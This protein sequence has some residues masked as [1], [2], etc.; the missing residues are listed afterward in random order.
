MLRNIKKLPIFIV[1]LV[2]ACYHSLANAND[3]P[4]GKLQ[5]ELVN[6]AFFQ[7]DRDYTGGLFIR[8][9]PL[10][11]AYTLRLGQEIYTPDHLGRSAPIND[12]HPYAGWSYLGASYKYQFSNRWIVDFTLDAGTI[13]PRSG[14]RLTQTFLHWI[15]SSPPPHG[16]DS[17]IFNEWGLMPE[18]KLDYRLP[19]VNL[20]GMNYRLVPYLRWKT[21]NIVR[22]Y[23]A[24]ITL[25]LGSSLPAFSAISLPRV[26]NQYWYFKLGM[27]HKA[28]QRNVLMEGNSEIKRGVKVFSYGVVPEKEVILANIGAFWGRNTYEFGF[29]IRYNTKIYTS[30]VRPDEGFLSHN[31]APM[32]NF[33]MSLIVTKQL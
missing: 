27:E 28:V 33:V 30:Q 3:S 24:G 15:V 32:G 25:L 1:S 21:G 13:G 22:D 8:W 7:T 4:R 18:L 20:G 19:K 29:N 9:S 14:A 11:K 16:W 2:T 17:Q 26:G 12:E 5:L 6:D 10:G 31:G 23:A